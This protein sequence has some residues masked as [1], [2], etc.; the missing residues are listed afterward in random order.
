[1][2]LLWG[3]SLHEQLP[4]V[5][6]DARQDA[7]WFAGK[8]LTGSPQPIL[9]AIQDDSTVG[10]DERQECSQ[11]EG[12]E[13]QHVDSSRAEKKKEN[14]TPEIAEPLRQ[15]PNPGDVAGVG[16]TPSNQGELAWRSVQWEDTDAP[17]VFAGGATLVGATVE[18]DINVAI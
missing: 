18:R 7:H 1:M 2:L 13:E 6:G 17:N 3:R 8:R 11:T 12:A 15:T 5:E 9:T 16:P 4:R 10:G 14:P